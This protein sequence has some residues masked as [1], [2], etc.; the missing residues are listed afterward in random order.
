MKNYLLR[1]E[2]FVRGEIKIHEELLRTKSNQYFI[3]L[4]GYLI[5]QLKPQLNKQQ[6]G[7]NLYAY[8]YYPRKVSINTM[9]NLSEYIPATSQQQ[10]H[11]PIVIDSG[12]CI[13][14]IPASINLLKDV[15]MAIIVQEAGTQSLKSYIE[16]NNQPVFGSLLKQLNSLLNF[17][18][19]SSETLST[20]GFFMHGDIHSGNIVV[21]PN[22]SLKLIDFGLATY[23]K[24]FFMARYELEDYLQ[25]QHNNDIYF[26]KISA[27]LLRCLYSKPKYQQIFSKFGTNSNI[28]LNYSPLFDIFCMLVVIVKSYLI[29]YKKLSINL[30]EDQIDDNFLILEGHIEL[31]GSST[32]IHKHYN[33]AKLIAKFYRQL[34]Y[35]IPPIMNG[36]ENISHHAINVFFAF[37]KENNIP[38]LD[39]IN[40]DDHPSQFN[41]LIQIIYLQLR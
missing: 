24:S 3:G 17:Y 14:N 6:S 38:A 11:I 16:N 31:I 7:Q 8:S 9:I 2:L 40:P 28:N 1:E 34:D 35:S 20:Y 4:I 18:R 15:H 30:T 19:V 29:L 27:K 37:C 5:P 26:R 10:Q 12:N 41:Q 22:G 33:L 25:K 39:D 23:T 21:M 32:P 13:I 36:Y